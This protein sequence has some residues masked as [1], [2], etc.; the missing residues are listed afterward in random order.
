MNEAQ[1]LA[2]IEK[3]KRVA[4]RSTIM[5]VVNLVGVTILGLTSG[6]MRDVCLHMYERMGYT[7]PLPT[8]ILL[9]IATPLRVSVFMV[10][11]SALIM[12]EFLVRNKETA[13][14]INM[15]TAFWL[16]AY[17]LLYGLVL[18]WPALTGGLIGP[19]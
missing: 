11:V 5:L 10:V 17:A 4:K 6:Y 2:G 14:R 3:D 12:K 15:F 7:L 16:L 1:L 18:L 13:L 19:M 8:K 9:S